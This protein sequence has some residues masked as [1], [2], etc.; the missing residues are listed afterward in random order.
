MLLRAL[1]NKQDIIGLSYM[2]TSFIT[3]MQESLSKKVN[4]VN[5]IL[6]L[7]IAYNKTLPI[8]ELED[9][10]A[11]LMQYENFFE[12]FQNNS[13][14]FKV[15]KAA[16]TQPSDSKSSSNPPKMYQQNSERILISK[17]DRDHSFSKLLDPNIEGGGEKYG[18]S[19]TLYSQYSEMSNFDSE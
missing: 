4:E 15:I 12:K 6:D 11:S 8:S 13:A 5:E 10:Q 14:V 9:M 1:L 19:S 18:G 2:S 3:K 16:M 17:R 7:E